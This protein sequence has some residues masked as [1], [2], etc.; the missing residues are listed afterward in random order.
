MSTPA[1]PSTRGPFLVG[2]TRTPGWYL[3]PTG[4]TG[5]LAK[6]SQYAT[7]EQA[8]NRGRNSSWAR[9]LR[10]ITLHE[11]EITAHRLDTRCDHVEDGVRCPRSRWAGGGFYCTD[12]KVEVRT[13]ATAIDDLLEES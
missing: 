11:A 7:E 10:I 12:H 2:N 1:T 4:G 3:S 5:D 6:A 13:D 8:R 9:D